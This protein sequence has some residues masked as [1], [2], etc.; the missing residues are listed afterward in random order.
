MEYGRMFT[1][2]MLE[3]MRFFLRHF[4]KTGL[5]DLR[6]TTWESLRIAGFVPEYETGDSKMQ[7]WRVAVVSSQ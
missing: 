5:E 3:G 2:D 4:L 1:S 6:D 7:F